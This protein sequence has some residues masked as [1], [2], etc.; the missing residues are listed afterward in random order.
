MAQA[1]DPSTLGGLDGQITRSKDRDH[2]GQHNETPSLLQIQKL[3]GH[4]GRRLKSQLLR[5]LRQENCL[6]TGGGGCSVPGDR[7]R[8]QPGKRARL[9]LQ[10]KKKKN[11]VVYQKHLGCLLK[12]E[13]QT[14]VFYPGNSGLAFGSH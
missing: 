5:R 4:G 8:L 12:I 2:P 11:Q 3:A 10:K 7:A 13:K 14:S 1:C 9:C 6:N